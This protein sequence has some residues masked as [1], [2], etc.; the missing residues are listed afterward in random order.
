MVFLRSIET[1]SEL[2]LYPEYPG[3]IALGLVCLRSRWDSATQ[4]L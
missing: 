1:M 4:Q 2:R 3:E